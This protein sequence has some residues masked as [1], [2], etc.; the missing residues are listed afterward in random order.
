MFPHAGADIPGRMPRRL[1]DPPRTNGRV[2]PP[3]TNTGRFGC[4]VALP[5]TLPPAPDV[6]CGIRWPTAA[7]GPR[8]GPFGY[9]AACAPRRAAS[10]DVVA[11]LSRRHPVSGAR[12]CACGDRYP[13]RD[14]SPRSGRYLTQRPPL[15]RRRG[16][17][18]GLGGD[19]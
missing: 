16:I 13:R 12:P 7:L 18:G 19:G 14:C 9:A 6:S 3:V 4:F 2:V 5:L 17:G 15:P 11:R 10:P 8:R 1:P